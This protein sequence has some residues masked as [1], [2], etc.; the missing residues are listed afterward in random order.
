MP[1]KLMDQAVIARRTANVQGRISTMGV[2]GI[3]LWYSLSDAAVLKPQIDLPQACSN[4]LD[5]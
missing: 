3:G 5:R 2:D 1:K 4:E